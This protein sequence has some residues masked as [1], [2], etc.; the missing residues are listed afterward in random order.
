MPRK[1][2]IEKRKKNEM[3]TISRVANGKMGTKN[4]PVLGG[5]INGL[6]VKPGDNAKYTMN[7]LAIAMLPDIDLKDPEQVRQRIERYF[8]LE[9]ETDSKPTVSGY[10]MALGLDRRRVHDIVN[11]NPT[12]PKIPP[13]CMDLIKKGYKVMENLWERYMNN[14]KINPVSGIFIAKNNYNYVDKV[15]HVV[16]PNVNN[17]EYDLQEIEKQYLLDKKDE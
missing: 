14:G 15:E 17:D 5:G 16:T 4:S 6:D 7:A 13:E 10:S 8:E 9:A 3:E 11:G 12:A 1:P 2:D